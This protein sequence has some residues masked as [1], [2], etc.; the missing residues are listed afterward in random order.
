[1]KK[2]KSRK[3]EKQLD[4][5]IIT[6]DEYFYFIAGYTSGG[7]PYGTTWEEAYAEGLLENQDED[8]QG[9][10]IREGDPFF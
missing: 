5:E 2:K 7:F 10:G 4:Y 6:Q 1:M 8:K 3:Y 9:G